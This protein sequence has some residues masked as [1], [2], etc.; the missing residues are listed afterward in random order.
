MTGLVFEKFLR[1]SVEDF[2]ISSLLSNYYLRIEYEQLLWNQFYVKTESCPKVDR[3][4]WMI[5]WKVDGPNSEWSWMTMDKR[6]SFELNRMVL[7]Q[8]GMSFGWKVHDAKSSR[9][10]SANLGGRKVWKWT[11]LKNQT[12]GSKRSVQP[13]PLKITSLLNLD[14]LTSIKFVLF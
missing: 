4:L 5:R 1:V 11:V 2:P 12:G 10:R 7:G 6:W 8:S 14:N 9:S 13:C 3:P